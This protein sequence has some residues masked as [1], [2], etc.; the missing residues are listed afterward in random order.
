MD[1]RRRPLGGASRQPVAGRLAI[2]IDG[3]GLLDEGGPVV[4]AIDVDDGAGARSGLA[5]GADIYP[6]PLADQELGGTRAKAVGLDQGPV[7][8]VDVD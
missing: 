3:I 8:G 4:Q 5:D 6:T 2:V 7:C 1:R